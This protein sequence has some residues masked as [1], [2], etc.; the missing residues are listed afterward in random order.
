MN[1]THSYIIYTTHASVAPFWLKNLFLSLSGGRLGSFAPPCGMARGRVGETADYLGLRVRVR[2]ME[3]RTHHF[4]VEQEEIVHFPVIAPQ[5]RIM[6]QTVASGDIHVHV[7]AIQEQ[8]RTHHSQAE[9]VVDIHVPATQAG[10]VHVPQPQE[11]VVN[12]AIVQSVDVP[13]PVMGQVQSL[14]P[15]L[16]QQARISHRHI[17]HVVEVPVPMA[18]EVAICMGPRSCSKNALTFACRANC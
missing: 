4:R 18:R 15:F 5:K 3:E 17:E 14:V 10:I 16:S 11:K 1:L 6:H 12:Q 7:P 9:Q 8:P 2:C 13:V